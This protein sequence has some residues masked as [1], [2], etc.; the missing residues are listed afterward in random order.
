[1]LSYE[2]RKDGWAF[3]ESSGGIGIV[4]TR[5]LWLEHGEVFVNINAANGRVRCRATN[6]RNVPIAGFGWESAVPYSGDTLRWAPQWT[7]AKNLSTL[8]GHGAAS[9]IRLEF[10]LTNARLYSLEGHFA[11]ISD[12]E[13]KGPFPPL[14]RPG[15]E[16]GWWS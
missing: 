13:C 5:I 2:L 9:V 14:A 6:S 10:E 1:M 8:S 12:T 11:P 7:G 3:L 15:F 16:P 4:G